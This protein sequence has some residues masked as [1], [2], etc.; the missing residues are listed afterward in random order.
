L[1]SFHCVSCVVVVA[2]VQRAKRIRRRCARTRCP[3]RTWEITTRY[4]ATSYGPSR[5]IPNGGPYSSETR[6]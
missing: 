4:C 6:S 1:V 3:L 5:R 2:R